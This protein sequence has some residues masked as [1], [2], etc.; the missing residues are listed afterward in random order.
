VRH[1]FFS[2]MVW[3][4]LAALVCTGCKH[5]YPI[6]APRV[7]PLVEARALTKAGKPQEAFERFEDMLRADP[8]NLSAQRGLVEAAYFAGRLEQVA[9]RY[10]SMAGGK[11]AG[12]GA[13]GLG[14]VEISRGPGHMQAALDQFTRAA[15]LLPAEADVPFRIGLV[16]LMN[17]DYKQAEK[18]L[19]QAV[20]KDPNRADIYVARGNALLG[21]GKGAQAVRSMAKILLL[22]PSASVASKACTVAAKVF[23]PLRGA[24]P[25]LAQDLEKVVELLDRDYVQQGLAEVLKILDRQPDN[26]FANVLKGLA[27]SRLQ[28]DGE[29]VVAF[30]HALDLRPESPLALI[31][32]GDVYA[33]L[34]KWGKA[35]AYYEKATSMNPFDLD[36]RTRM[37]D[38]A[39][40]R[41]DYA[42]AAGVYASLVLLAPDKIDY[43]YQ[44]ALALFSA[45]RIR[46]AV[47]VY[48][49]ILEIKADDIESLVRLGSLYAALSKAEPEKREADRGRARAFLERAHELSPDNQAIQEM[50]A[51]VED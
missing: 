27:H 49:G 35:R 48:E 4:G 37:G 7:D 39:R 16:Y 15:E 20:H 19:E 36:A 8:K 1:R 23:D 43:R 26:P 3:L 14:L 47:G 33:R 6:P 32:L 2:Y 29:A 45:G 40:K 24:D 5:R 13:Y 12:I 46:E 28:N 18:Y 44:Y 30:E 21:Q 17:G 11:S 51:K 10:E 9:R 34:Q 25:D 50:L 38:M 41:R 22:S 42:R 31:G